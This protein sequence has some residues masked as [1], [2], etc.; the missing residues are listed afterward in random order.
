MFTGMQNA[1]QIGQTP[2]KPAK[3]GYI[4]SIQDRA[5]CMLTGMQNASKLTCYLQFKR[6]AAT[7]L[8][9]LSKFSLL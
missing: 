5:W 1:S 4:D 6:I 7:T 2:S 8:Y 9:Y 3:S